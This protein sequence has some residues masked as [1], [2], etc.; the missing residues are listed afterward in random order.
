MLFGG[1]G[2]QMVFDTCNG[3]AYMSRIPGHRIPRPVLFS[4]QMHT[5]GIT[6]RFPNIAAMETERRHSERTMTALFDDEKFHIR[7]QLCP[8]YCSL[9]YTRDSVKEIKE[10]LK[11]AKMHT[12][13]SKVTL[14]LARKKYHRLKREEKAESFRK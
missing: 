5:E 7:S 9:R 4:F 1:V 10:E 3:S 13:L 2:V 12:Q 6:M 11:R 14:Q 8:Y